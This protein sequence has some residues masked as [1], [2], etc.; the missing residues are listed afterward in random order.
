MIIQNLMVFQKN[1][2]LLNHGFIGIKKITYKPIEGMLL[3]FRSYLWHKVNLK[4]N[5]L[6]DRII[7]SWDLK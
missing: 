1:V 4:N 5:N 2:N 6:K 7:I 3:I